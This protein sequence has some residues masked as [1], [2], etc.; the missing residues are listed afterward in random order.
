MAR[1]SVTVRTDSAR[2]AFL[3]TLTAC[4]NVTAACK[5]AGIGRQ[6]AYQWR[7]DDPAFAVA[8]AG[9]LEEAVDALEKE[10]WRRAAEGVDKP[11]V[12]QGVVT[13]S[14]REYSDRLMEILL[15]AHRPDKYIER[16]R[17]ENLHA[18]SITIQGPAA[19]L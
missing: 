18:V 8:W 12:F 16:V 15:K 4:C 14:Y 1:G 7:E 2:E 19:D 9:A 6:T 3:E 17:S 13:G 11:I 5:A 10:A